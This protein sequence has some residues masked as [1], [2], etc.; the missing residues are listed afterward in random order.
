MLNFENSRSSQENI[1][2]KTE[3]SAIANNE[4]ESDKNEMK[5]FD[6]KK[7]LFEICVYFVCSNMNHA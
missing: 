4:T 2:V 5:I 3:K 1:N 7:I 6:R